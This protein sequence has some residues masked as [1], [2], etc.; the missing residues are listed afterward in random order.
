MTYEVLV[1]CVSG[2][3]TYKSGLTWK[4]VMAILQTIEQMGG[5]IAELLV[6]NTPNHGEN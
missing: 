4:Q 2:S 5:T 3:H 1:L 6:K